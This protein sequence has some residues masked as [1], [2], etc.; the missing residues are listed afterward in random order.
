M[1]FHQL[2]SVTCGTNVNLES[3]VNEIE[4]RERVITRCFV[5]C[6]LMNKHLEWH[7][8]Y[9]MKWYGHRRHTKFIIIQPQWIFIWQ[10]WWSLCALCA[11][12]KTLVNASLS[13]TTFDS[14]IPRESLWSSWDCTPCNPKQSIGKRFHVSLKHTYYNL[15]NRKYFFNIISYSWR[16]LQQSCCCVELI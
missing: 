11:D 9:G 16:I 5:N 7:P 3:T 2:H 14:T 12:R 1:K 6:L 10:Y 4:N 13:A 8:G 15:E